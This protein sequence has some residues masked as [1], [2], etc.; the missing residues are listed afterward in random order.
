MQLQ[1]QL[2]SSSHLC[3]SGIPKIRTSAAVT[4]ILRHSYHRVPGI[5]Q[6]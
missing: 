2:R 1:Q 5:S 4:L 6:L 3:V